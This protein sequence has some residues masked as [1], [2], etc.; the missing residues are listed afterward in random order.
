[1]ANLVLQDDTGTVP[2]ANAY[3][4][5]TFFKSYHDSRNQSYV[6]PNTSAPFADDQI[7]GAIVRATDYIDKRFA[8]IGWR[9]YTNQPTAWPR[10]DAVDINDRF[11]KGIPIG[12][13]QAT[14]EYALRAL[15]LTLVT[16]PT[17]DPSG[18]P[19]R[20]VTTKVG[21]V[22]IQ[23]YFEAEGFEMP[24]YPAADRILTSWGLVVRG[25]T[26]QRA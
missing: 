25:G 8:F 7:A 18:R 22:E 24:R 9:R 2:G 11:L 17:R 1:M 23:T 6:D 15:S 10:W 3:V 14:A 13:Q 20:S 16:D 19:L 5:L 21:P 26:I 12:V 4:D